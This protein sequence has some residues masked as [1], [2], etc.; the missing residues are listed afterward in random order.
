MLTHTW[1]RIICCIGIVI[2][3][4]CAVTVNNPIDQSPVQTAP[5]AQ[6]LTP[7]KPM[8]DLN[9]ISIGMSIDQV[10]SVIGDE[11]PVG[12]TVKEE[13]QTSRLTVKS[14]QKEETLNV[15]GFSYQ[16]LYY[17]TC[18]VH[19]DDQI[20]EDE[21]TPLVFENGILIARTRDDFNRIK[22]IPISNGNF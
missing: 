8:I 12:F 21:M 10:K 1:Q 17:F 4:G 18:I 9:Q 14:L 13:G 15:Q 2:C 11:I 20:T 16:V 19:P 3:G 5:T 6:T 7:P 22:S